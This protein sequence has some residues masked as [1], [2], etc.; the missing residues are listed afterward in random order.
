MPLKLLKTS[1]K[2][3]PVYARYQKFCVHNNSLKDKPNNVQVVALEIGWKFKKLLFWAYLKPSLTQQKNFSIIIF[4]STL[5]TF[6]KR[7]VSKTKRMPKL[8][9]TIF[10]TSVF[11][12]IGIN[13]HVYRWQKCVYCNDFY[14]DL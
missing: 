5:S 6:C 9:L 4:L 13:T 1:I 8:S 12:I 2:K 7:N 14:F 10:S 11:Y 3:L